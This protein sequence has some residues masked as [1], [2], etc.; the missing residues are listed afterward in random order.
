MPDSN[1]SQTKGTAIA[2][3]L[4]RVI[5]STDQVARDLKALAELRR[6]L[7]I[8][9]PN[10]AWHSLAESAIRDVHARLH[11]ASLMRP[12]GTTPIAKAAG[13][14]TSTVSGA[15]ASGEIPSERS[16]AGEYQ[17]DPEDARRWVESR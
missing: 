15:C 8:T 7:L 16:D 10:S 9:D 3:A 17:V 2:D 14:S 13:V 6:V 12:L 11:R 4:V 1:S 5:S